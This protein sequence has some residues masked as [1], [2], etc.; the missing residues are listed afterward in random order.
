M[1]D[2]EHP[3]QV[4]GYEGSL[5]QLTCAIHGM[6]YDQVAEFYR[7]SAVELRRQSKGDERRGR[8]KLSRRL[9]AAA[10][11]ASLLHALM[12]SVWRLCE[13]HMRPDR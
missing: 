10:L 7:L 1:T 4:A 8:P 12:L 9:R 5:R 13:P 2:Q 11:A 3:Q 6:R